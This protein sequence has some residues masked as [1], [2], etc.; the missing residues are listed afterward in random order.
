MITSKLPIY[1]VQSIT[2]IIGKERYELILTQRWQFCV[3][4]RTPRCA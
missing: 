2:F 3:L 4:N 1:N